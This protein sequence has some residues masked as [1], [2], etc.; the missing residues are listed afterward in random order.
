VTFTAQYL[1]LNIFEENPGTFDIFKL[2]F[3]EVID[4]DIADSTCTILGVLVWDK[5]GWDSEVGF[6]GHPPGPRYF[7][8]SPRF[9]QITITPSEIAI[10]IDGTP[11][12]GGTTRSLVA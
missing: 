5:I 10:S 9:V 7:L 8:Q 3:Q 4:F 2:Y 1:E 12:I 6:T 11:A